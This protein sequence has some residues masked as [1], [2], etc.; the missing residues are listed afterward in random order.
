MM[1]G[2]GQDSLQELCVLW[3]AEVLEVAEVGDELRLVEHFLHGEV[4]EIDGI[5]KTLH[6]LGAVSPGTRG[7]SANGPRARARSARSLR[8]AGGL[9]ARTWAWAWARARAR[10][11]PWPS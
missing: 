11:W 9:V 3:F 1:G 8:S 5:G 7:R 10:A 2:N 4:I 6:E